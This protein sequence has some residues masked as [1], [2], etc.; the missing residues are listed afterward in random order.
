MSNVTLCY[1]L[2]VPHVKG[3][4]SDQCDGC[5]PPVK[6]KMVWG[7]LRLVRVKS[8]R[9]HRWPRL[10]ANTYPGCWIGLSLYYRQ[11]GIAWLWGRP[12][13]IRG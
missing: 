13:A 4:H 8:A 10:Y 3:L 12:G 5:R 7:P 9:D 6:F 11:N 1:G 2:D